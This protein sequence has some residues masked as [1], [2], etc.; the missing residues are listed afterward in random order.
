MTKLGNMIFRLRFQFGQHMGFDI[1]T[2][3]TLQTFPLLFLYQ[4]LVFG[5]LNLLQSAPH[6]EEKRPREERSAILVFTHQWQQG[7]LTPIQS[8]KEL[9]S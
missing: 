1:S 7:N 4:R 8:T 6:S 9:V 2:T 5:I 3:F